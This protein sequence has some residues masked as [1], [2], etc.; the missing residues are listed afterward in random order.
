MIETGT[1]GCTRNQGFQKSKYQNCM[2]SGSGDI[3]DLLE[4][5]HQN[6]VKIKKS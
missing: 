6:K 1:I 3:N 4:H 2:P 5:T